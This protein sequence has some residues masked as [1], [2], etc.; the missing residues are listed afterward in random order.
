MHIY[1]G[2]LYILYSNLCTTLFLHS[3]SLAAHWTH[4]VVAFCF[5]YNFNKFT[6]I[7]FDYFCILLLLL[8]LLFYCIIFCCFWDA[9]DAAATPARHDLPNALTSRVRTERDSPLATCH[10]VPAQSLLQSRRAALLP[11][12]LSAAAQTVNKQPKRGCTGEGEECSGGCL[13]WGCHLHLA[14]AELVVAQ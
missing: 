6:K 14:W 5:F 2:I 10:A 11:A 4:F 7:S 9:R 13:K 12:S 8:L 3:I 1:I